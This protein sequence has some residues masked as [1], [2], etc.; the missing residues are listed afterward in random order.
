MSG[1]IEFSKMCVKLAT[2]A[3]IRIKPEKK[4]FSTGLAVAENAE[5]NPYKIMCLFEE[6]L[7]SWGELNERA[8]QFARFLK[9]SGVQRGDVVSLFMENRIEHFIISTAICKIGA[10]AGLIN[11]SLTG[12]SLEHCIE[13]IK[14]K[15]LIFGSELIESVEQIKEMLTLKKRDDFIAIDDAVCKTGD[16]FGN[17]DLYENDYSTENLAETKTIPSNSPGYYIFT[18]GTTG[19]PKA[20]VITYSR[21]FRVS[22]VFSRIA[23]KL[24]PDDRLYICVPLY[25]GNAL[26]I[27]FG[28]ILD[29]GAS[30]HLARHFSAGSFWN[31]IRKHQSNSFVYVGELCRYLLLQPEREDDADNPA[32]K[33]MGNGLRPDIWMAFKNRFGLATINEYYGATEGNAGCINLFHKDLTVGTC[34]VKHA[35][36]AYD[37]NEDTI[38]R[39]HKGRCTKVTQGRPGLLL[40]EISGKATFDGYTNRQDTEK[41]IVR[42]VFKKGDR[43]F[44]TGDLLKEVYVGF[45]FFMPHYAFEDRTGDTYRWK[46]ENVSTNEIGDIINNCSD[47]TM[48]NVYGVKVPETEGRAGM[49][50]LVLNVESPDMTEISYHIQRT[51]PGYA[52]PLFLRLLDNMEVT[53]TLK[54]KKQRL[55]EE[56]FHPDKCSDRV[57]VL[58]PGAELYEPLDSVFYQ[59]IMMGTAGY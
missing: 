18:S 22:G 6:R 43:Y 40:I 44:N 14:S 46:G 47:V 54:L 11:T 31:D 1:L 32:I 12:H 38:I 23:L 17:F 53:N 4:F 33:C 57:Y 48:C 26:F 42:D 50:A 37:I 39:N 35:L 51:I 7:I 28:T 10:I 55:K 29:S 24:K 27:G 45:T 36:V 13:T 56:A 5:R 34:P 41:K 16:W 58:K 30:I 25:H 8:N 21:L 20:S 49:A 2:A 9:A 59:T 52:R 3:F 15:K 19:L